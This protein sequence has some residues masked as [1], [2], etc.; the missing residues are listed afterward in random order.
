M[1]CVTAKEH[2]TMES[3]QAHLKYVARAL[4]W[5]FLLA[6][7]LQVMALTLYVMSRQK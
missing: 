6:V 7:A 3:P 1:A 5:S 2:D 4:I